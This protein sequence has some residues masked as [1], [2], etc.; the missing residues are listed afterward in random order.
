MGLVPVVDDGVPFLRIN[1]LLLFF[2]GDSFTVLFGTC[3]KFKLSR[4]L[5][6][7][8]HTM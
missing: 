2:F 5:H 8:S 6:T 7:E 4:S 1:L 3:G